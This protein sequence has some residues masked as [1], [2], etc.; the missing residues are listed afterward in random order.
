MSTPADTAKNTTKFS[1]FLSSKKLD[2]RRLLAVSARLEHLRP[3]DRAI[4][5]A[6]R[7]KKSAEGGGAKPA[8]GADKKKPRSGRAL[9]PRALTAALTGKATVSGPQRT[10]FLKAI[11]AL[12]EQKK[13]EPATLDL[14]FSDRAQ[15]RRKAK[16]TAK[17]R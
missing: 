8:E 10:R 17:T 2:P 14:L 3:E 15:P 12:L 4:R 5:L 6:Q 11:N 7:R 16:P 9:T 13:Q 1:E